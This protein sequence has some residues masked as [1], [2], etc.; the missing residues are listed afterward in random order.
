MYTRGFWVD[1]GDVS[2]F[3]W[4][5]QKWLP[6]LAVLKRFP[7]WTWTSRLDHDS[8]TACHGYLGCYRLSKTCLS[9]YLF[10]GPSNEMI[11]YSAWGSFQMSPFFHSVMSHFHVQ[12]STLSHSP[13]NI[14]IIL[15]CVDQLKQTLC[16]YQGT[17]LC[18]MGSLHW[19]VKM[20]AET[21]LFEGTGGCS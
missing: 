3:P 17:L 9:L 5:C 21:L 16:V 13:F 6:L 12:T 18:I 19:Y 20:C 11:W 15:V 2:F 10:W 8:L 1:R 14:Y 7:S 4:S